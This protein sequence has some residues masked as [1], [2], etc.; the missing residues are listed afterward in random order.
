VALLPNRKS[1]LVLS[2]VRETAPQAITGQALVQP[3][4]PKPAMREGHD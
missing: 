2:A 3:F 1:V 4:H